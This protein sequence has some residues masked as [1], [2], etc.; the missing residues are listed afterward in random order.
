MAFGFGGPCEKF[1]GG[2]NESQQSVFCMFVL[3][4]AYE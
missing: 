2:A 1:Y 4:K 3:H